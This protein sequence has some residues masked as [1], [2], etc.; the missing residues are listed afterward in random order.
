VTNSTPDEQL[1][2]LRNEQF[3]SNKFLS[4]KKRM[5]TFDDCTFV[6]FI[7]VAIIFYFHI[8]ADDEF[9]DD[10]NLEN[11]SSNFDPRKKNI[12]IST[13]L[14]GQTASVITI[15]NKCSSN[16]IKKKQKTIH[17]VSSKDTNDEL[18]Y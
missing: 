14:P 3:S 11:S 13:P 9:T 5:A 18:V 2:V 16:Q 15:V 4:K 1:N 6:F 8:A 7:L 17:H 12:S 10:S